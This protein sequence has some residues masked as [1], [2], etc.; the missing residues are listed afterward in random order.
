LPPDLSAV[1]GASAR[2][3]VDFDVARF[4]A[5]A[6]R[7]LGPLTGSP[8][9]ER[10]TGGQSNPTYF[11]TYDQA[12]WVLRKQPNGP[13]LPSAHAVDREHRVMAALAGTDVPVP[14][15]L[16][17]CADTAV[18]GTPFYLMERLDGRVF[19]QCWLPNVAP[20]ERR[21]M[22]FAMA[23]TLAK[24]HRVDW[25]GVGLADYGRS[26]SYFARQTARWTKQWGASKT[27]E[28]ADVEH[29]IT[30]LPTHLP[31]D[32][33]TTI[34]H[35]DFRMGNLMF[36]PTE[37]KVIAVLDW[38]LSTLGHPLGDLAYSALAWQLLPHE[39]MGMRGHDSAA[40]GIPTVDEYLARYYALRPEAGRVTAFHKAFALFRLA[41]IFEG[42]AARAKLGS[43]SGDDATRIGELS[44]AC[45]RYG[46]EAIAAA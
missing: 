4:D 22:F 30:W 5:Y 11:I 33:L 29:L 38:E 3:E 17:F 23:E 35:G 42:I 18:I 16:H 6:R 46:V 36:H 37:P 25:A 41:I 10:I 2:T 8:H 24:L 26:G 32:E 39:H 28:S 19:N 1:S 13:V 20:S 14:R 12:R 9:V 34:A 44:V 45:A 7:T 31:E 40:S 21:V 15:M 43:A 27:R